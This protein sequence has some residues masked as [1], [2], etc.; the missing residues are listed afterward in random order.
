MNP[1]DSKGAMS[2]DM[3]RRQFV[4]GAALAGA[5]AL[6]ETRRALASGGAKIG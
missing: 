5:A 2:F 1:D 3:G 4:K 6:A